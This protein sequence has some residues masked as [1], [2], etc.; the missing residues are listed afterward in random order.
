MFDSVST[1]LRRVAGVFRPAGRP[2]PAPVGD[3]AAFGRWG[4]DVAAAFL[5][6]EGCRILGRRVRPNRHDEIDIVARDGDSIVFVEVKS[7]RSEAFGRPAAAIRHD[8]RRALNRAASAYLRQAGFPKC[9]YRFD[10]VEVVAD[11]GTPDAPP[12]VRRIRNALPFDPR[13][14]TPQPAVA[15]L[16]G[17]APR[18]APPKPPRKPAAKGMLGFSSRIVRR[19]PP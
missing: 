15:R 18:G 9:F 16:P 4:E 5:E 14:R 19:P 2:G 6:R 7:R 3:S 8:K 12:E 10:V 17:G 11:P 13:R 1:F